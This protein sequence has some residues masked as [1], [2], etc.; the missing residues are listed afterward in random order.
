VAEAPV[1]V[2]PFVPSLFEGGNQNDQRPSTGMESRGV[3][4]GREPSAKQ[5][6]YQGFP[7]GGH[8]L[9]KGPAERAITL[10]AMSLTELL[11]ADP[12]TRGRAVACR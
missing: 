7:K 10:E 6:P 8:L 9:P 11:I 5:M 12:L 1:A 2:A 3:S 4:L